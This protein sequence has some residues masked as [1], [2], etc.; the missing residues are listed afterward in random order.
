MPG[1]APLLLVEQSAR[2]HTPTL[3]P[4]PE[5]EA[6]AELPAV[7]PVLVLPVPVLVVL[8]VPLL[9]EQSA[10][11]HTPTLIPGPEVE[12]EVGGGVLAVL[13]P[14]PVLP[15]LAEQL[16]RAQ[17]PT[18][19]PEPEVAGVVLVP[20]WPPPACV[21]DPRPLAVPGPV[22]RAVK[23]MAGGEAVEG[24]DCAAWALVWLSRNIPLA[25]AA[26]IRPR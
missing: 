16:A 18:L 6:G 14:V 24:G 19:I 7:L 12:V 8:P 9:V 3:I 22:V 17:T 2:A 13:L 15:L 4:D 21:P 25:P 26:R 23:V 1:L 10:T 20:P 11:A 5:P